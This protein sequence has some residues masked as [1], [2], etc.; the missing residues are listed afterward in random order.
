M[1][2]HICDSLKPT[3]GFVRLTDEEAFKVSQSTRDAV[4]LSKLEGNAFVVLSRRIALD[5]GREPATLGIVLGDSFIEPIDNQVDR[6]LR[7][8]ARLADTGVRV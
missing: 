4:Y 1:R 2:K 3:F 8:R 5:E 7:H 6:N